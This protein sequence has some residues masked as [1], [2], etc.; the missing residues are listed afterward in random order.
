MINA[1]VQGYGPVEELLFFNS[2]AA[3]LQPDLVIETLFV[4]NDAEEAVTSRGKAQGARP[5]RRDAVSGPSLCDPPARIVASMECLQVL[6]LRRG[7]ATERCDGNT[8]HA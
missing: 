2:L 4:G 8:R 5:G 6:R 7:L 1:G 3:T